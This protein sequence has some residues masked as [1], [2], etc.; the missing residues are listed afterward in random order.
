VEHMEDSWSGFYRWALTGACSGILLIGGMA[1]GLWSQ[2]I[3]RRL[4]DIATSQNKQWD[5]L[6]ERASLPT[7]VN[8][9]ERRTEDLEQRLRQVERRVWGGE[10]R[11]GR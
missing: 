2:S 10:N 7:R 1:I 11:G 3:D 4:D 8:E 5:V 6:N 9:G